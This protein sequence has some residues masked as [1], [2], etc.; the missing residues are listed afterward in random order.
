[1]YRIIKLLLII[2]LIG[3]SDDRVIIP[4]LNDIDHLEIKDEKHNFSYDEFNKD[5]INEFKKVLAGR[6]EKIDCYPA[7]F[8]WFMK[9]GEI[10]LN[11]AYS[12]SPDCPFLIIEKNHKQT[13]Y[14]LNY[15][16]GMYLTEYVHKLQQKNEPNH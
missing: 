8:I 11:I 16:S 5:L 15:Q 2:I 9:G 6:P 4:D 1:M 7:G 3:C 14:R 10:R 12:N 13:G